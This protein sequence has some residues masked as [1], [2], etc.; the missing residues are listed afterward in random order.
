MSSLH[1]SMYKLF[2]CKRMKSSTL[3]YVA[4]V[5]HYMQSVAYVDP[6]FGIFVFPKIPWNCL[7]W[8]SHSV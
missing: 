7:L 2:E 4:F 8:E 6:D 5:I 1:K 3:V